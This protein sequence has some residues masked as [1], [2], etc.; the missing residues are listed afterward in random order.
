MAGKIGQTCYIL[1]TFHTSKYLLNN[2]VLQSV[3]VVSDTVLIK[4]TAE[5]V[6]CANPPPHN[7]IKYSHCRC[8]L[9]LLL[10]P[11]LLN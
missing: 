3:L 10:L 11:L 8:R 1:F 2:S 4:V 7:T 9:F 6:G 5:Q